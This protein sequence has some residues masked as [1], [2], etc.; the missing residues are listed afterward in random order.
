MDIVIKS[1]TGQS[2]IINLLNINSVS[3]LKQ[4]LSNAYGLPLYEIN[5]I[6]NDIHLFD[7]Y[8]LDHYDI[9][10]ND[11]LY[12][13]LDIQG[14]VLMIIG[15][16]M[17]VTMF[18]G[19]AIQANEDNRSIDE[20]CD[21]AI[22]IK[23]EIVDMLEWIRGIKKDLKDMTAN[24]VSDITGEADTRLKTLNAEMINMQEKQKIDIDSK[25]YL[26]TFIAG[27]LVIL[28]IIKYFN[29]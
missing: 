6:H 29:K 11:T 9:Q 18:A 20:K 8:T 4:H 7:L 22:K 12:L 2:F 16:I 1:I 24:T 19:T 15:G 28:F 14:G 25:K 21:E 23:N 17:M 27:V 10:E 13:T 5:L 3:D 26:Y